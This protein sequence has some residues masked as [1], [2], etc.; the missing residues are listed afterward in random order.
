MLESD[1]EESSVDPEEQNQR[2]GVRYRKGKRVKTVGDQEGLAVHLIPITQH[3][4]QE[5]ETD[6]EEEKEREMQRQILPPDVYKRASN[7]SES[8]EK[9][10]SHSM[11]DLPVPETR[12]RLS[13]DFVP[14]N[15]MSFDSGNSPR[16]EFR[17]VSPQ[18]NSSFERILDDYD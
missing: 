3:N 13:A 1:P 2:N 17:P 10:D 5:E 14:Q 12:N 16:E 15:L 11:K 4:E 18:Q 7:A 8:K 6:E 9:K